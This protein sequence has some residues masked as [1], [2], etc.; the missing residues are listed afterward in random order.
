MWIVT[1]NSD[2]FTVFSLTFFFVGMW[3]H[4]DGG[5]TP[6]FNSS[7]HVTGPGPNTTRDLLDF[8]REAK[9]RNIFVTLSLWNGAAVSPVMLLFNLTFLS[10]LTKTSYL[11]R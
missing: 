2:L 11:I 8:V 1:L 3:V 7:G 9:K 4:V 5:R 10:I 6:M